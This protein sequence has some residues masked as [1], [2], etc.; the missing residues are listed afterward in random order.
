MYKQSGRW[1]HIGCA[2]DHSDYDHHANVIPVDVTVPGCPPPPLE[3]MRG[4]HSAVRQR[5]TTLLTSPVD[6]FC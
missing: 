5:Q 6:S 4:I 1:R 2:L 3:I